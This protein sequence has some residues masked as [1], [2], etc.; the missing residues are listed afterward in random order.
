MP[1]AAL[2]EL[3]SRW[4]AIEEEELAANPASSFHHAVLAV[5]RNGIASL[6]GR[7]AN[8]FRRAASARVIASA[9]AIC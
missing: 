4:L 9:T 3:V 5:P 2:N 1:E 8:A 6:P 7:I